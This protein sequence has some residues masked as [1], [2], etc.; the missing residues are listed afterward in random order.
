MTRVNTH[1]ITECLRELADI[2]YQKR[3]W[4]ASSGHEVSSFAEAVCQL[5][6]DSGLG[7][8]LDR[9]DLVFSKDI[10]SRLGV[11]RRVLGEIDDGR[12]PTDIVADPKMQ[13]VRTLSQQ[14]IGLMA[15]NGIN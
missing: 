6:N 9:V 4:F 15:K 1:G 12:S 14:L 3:V 2:E 8:E 5:F 11:L 13:N 10:D 7:A